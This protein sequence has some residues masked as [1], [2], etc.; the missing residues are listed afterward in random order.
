VAAPASLTAE[1]AIWSMPTVEEVVKRGYPAEKWHAIKA[2]RDALVA[3]W[4]A[5]PAFRIEMAKAR[6]DGLKEEASRAAERKAF[7]AA[8]KAERPT[9]PKKGA[10]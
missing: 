1:T 4:N 10:P 7:D 3:R 6:A 2:E 8:Q 9:A 5:E